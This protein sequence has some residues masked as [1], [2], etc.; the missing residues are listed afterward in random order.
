MRPLLGIKLKT[1]QS[2][3]RYKC[4]PQSKEHEMTGAPVPV[5]KCASWDNAQNGSNSCGILVADIDSSRPFAVAIAL[6]IRVTPLQSAAVLLSFGFRPQALSDSITLSNYL[7]AQRGDSCAV[8]C[9]RKE[10][11][12]FNPKISNFY[13][14][15]QHVHDLLGHLQCFSAK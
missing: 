1:G 2:S 4:K 14:L 15:Q 9:A 13:Y 11:Y 7:E 10:A 3:W 12:R 6:S 8:E 5:K